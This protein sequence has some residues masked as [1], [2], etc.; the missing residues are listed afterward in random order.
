MPNLGNLCKPLILNTE[1][2]IEN[3]THITHDEHNCFYH[4]ILSPAINLEF[5]CIYPEI[6]LK[7]V[8]FTLFLNLK[9]VFLDH[10]HIIDKYLCNLSSTI[11]TV[12][13]DIRGSTICG[14]S[15]YVFV[16]DNL[17]LNLKKIIFQCNSYPKKNYAKIRLV[18]LGKLKNLKFH[19]TVK[20]IFLHTIL[21]VL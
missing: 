3:V 19:L 21:T 13:F 18:I 2:K 5:L 1:K 9:T 11:E 10:T 16:F 12:F 17:P 7:C 15:D 14:V 8:D 6:N 4:N 20:F